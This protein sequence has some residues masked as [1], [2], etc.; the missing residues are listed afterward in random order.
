MGLL[1]YLVFTHTAPDS[2]TS[3]M[4]P[5]MQQFRAAKERHPGMLVLF[6]NGDFYELFEADAELGHR[7]ARSHAHA[8]R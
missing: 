8:P 6:R 5:M 4:T 2:G 1:G 3:R 7:V